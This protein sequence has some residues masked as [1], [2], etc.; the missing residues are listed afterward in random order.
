[1]TRLLLTRHGE[2][3][4][5]VLRLLQGQMPGELTDLGKE[6]ARQLAVSLKGEHIDCIVSSDLKRAADTARIIS[7]VLGI[8]I[9][10]YEPLIRERDFGA[11]TGQ[12]YHG[13]TGELDSSAETIEAIFARATK[14]LMKMADQYDGKRVLVVSH[15][16]FLRVIQGVFY[17]KTIRDIVPMQNAEVREICIVSPE[18]IGKAEYPMDDLVAES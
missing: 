5:N 6:Q 3:R 8:G 10:E 17:G 1:M 4:E 11:H 2:T 9:V 14:W 12:P 7:E 16:L 13:M 15:G 18:Q